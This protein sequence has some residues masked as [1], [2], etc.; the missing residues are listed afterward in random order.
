MENLQ[1]E[2][3]KVMEQDPVKYDS[4]EAAIALA[5]QDIAA[6]SVVGSTAVTAPA[7]AAAAVVASA[8]TRLGTTSC[9]NSAD[10]M[11]TVN[12]KKKTKKAM[13]CIQDQAHQLEPTTESTVSQVEPVVIVVVGPGRGPLIRAS[14][15]ASRST[16]V[17]IRVHAV[18]KNPNAVITLRNRVKTDSWVEVTVHQSDMR[19]WVPP[20]LAD[21]LVSELLGSWGD[22]E[23]G[24]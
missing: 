10:N 22:N 11:N 20:E 24:I 17:P 1:S 7:P 12:T 14:I 9:T 21:I 16:G 2:T 23:V 18:E 4:Y 13:K 8:A 19:T 5:L 15:R 6:R 3:Y